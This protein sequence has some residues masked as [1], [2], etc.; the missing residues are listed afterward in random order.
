MATG[1]GSRKKFGAGSQGKGDG[2]GA[3]TVLP[4][5][6]LGENMVLSNRDKAQHN[7]QRGLDSRA[8]QTEQYHDHIANQRHGDEFGD[9]PAE[10]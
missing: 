1:R 7:D 4:S 2:S 9:L 3:M 5:G 8:V 6:V 10:D